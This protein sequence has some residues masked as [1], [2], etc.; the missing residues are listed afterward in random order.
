[1]SF[2]GK[3]KRRD[4]LHLGQENLFTGR[5]LTQAANVVPDKFRGSPN[6]VV[7]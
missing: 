3:S 1:L 6:G 2:F 4:V 5:V 7:V